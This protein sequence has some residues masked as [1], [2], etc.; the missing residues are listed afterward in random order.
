[1]IMH[2]IVNLSLKIIIEICHY[3]KH[4]IA[5]NDIMSLNIKKTHEFKI[6]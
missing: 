3:G 4:E 6:S 2:R 5:V 1:M